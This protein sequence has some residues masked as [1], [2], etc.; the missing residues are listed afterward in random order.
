MRRCALFSLYLSVVEHIGEFEEPFSD[1]SPSRHQA[2][3][4]QTNENKRVRSL[5]RRKCF[6]PVPTNRRQVETRQ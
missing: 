2:H 4:Y 1:P 3:K 5:G 6:V